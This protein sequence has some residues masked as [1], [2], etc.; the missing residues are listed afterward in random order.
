TLT[1]LDSLDL[2][3][4]EPS[5]LKIDA[6]GYELEILKGAS[7]SIA[8]F[9]AILLEIAIIEINECAPLLH[10]VVAFMDKLGFVTCE[11]LEMHRRPLDRALSQIDVFFLRRESALFADR[12]YSA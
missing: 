11:I 1:T 10:E 2:R 3:F 6:Q 9:E 5:F 4:E 7:N 12:R 8:C